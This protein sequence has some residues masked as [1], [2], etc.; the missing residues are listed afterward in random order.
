[1][2]FNSVS[3]NQRPVFENCPDRSS[4]TFAYPNDENEA[5]HRLKLPLLA[6]RDNEH[7]SQI[8]QSVIIRQM[9]EI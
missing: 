2:T 4:N 6:V 3:D 7:A 1:M 9:G 8:E 5:Y